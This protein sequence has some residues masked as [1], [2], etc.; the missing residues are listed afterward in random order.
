MLAQT[1]RSVVNDR[2]KPEEFSAPGAVRLGSALI[3]GLVMTPISSV[4]GEQRPQG[5]GGDECSVGL[6]E[7]KRLV[8]FVCLLPSSLTAG[9][10]WMP[11]C[12]CGGTRPRAQLTSRRDGSSTSLCVILS[13]KMM[14]WTS[15]LTCRVVD[16]ALC[17]CSLYLIR[18]HGYPRVISP[19]EISLCWCMT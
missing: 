8:T 4:L 10:I 7:V 19:P 2:I 12:T 3:P 5:G 1:V 9:A 15:T 11:R 6:G 13:H 16:A 14:P 18:W 17:S